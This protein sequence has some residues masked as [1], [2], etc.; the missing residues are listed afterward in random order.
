M[1][2][3]YG[4]AFASEEKSAEWNETVIEYLRSR[5]ALKILWLLLDSRHGLKSADRQFLRTL[6][7]YVTVTCLLRCKRQPPTPTQLL[8]R[9]LPVPRHKVPFRIVLTKGDLV[10]A[11]DLVRQHSMLHQELDGEF[12]H[13]LSHGIYMVSSSTRAGID[14]IQ[15]EITSVALNHARKLRRSAMAQSHAVVAKQAAPKTPKTP[16]SAPAAARTTNQTAT[17]RAAKRPPSPSS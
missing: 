11:E 5:K 7:L 10:H 8:T 4:Y 2:C 6:K 15:R 3:S 9:L 12:A 13:A 1:P 16:P 14:T 17:K